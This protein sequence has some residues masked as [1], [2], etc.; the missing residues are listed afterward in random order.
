[1]LMA[2]AA[3]VL[4][5]Q[6]KAPVPDAARL[7]SAEAQVRDVFKPELA[8]A[9]RK[10]LAQDFLRVAGDT[11]D[12][13]AARYVL[14]R[15][16]ASYAAQAGDYNA[17]VQAIDEVS[18]RFQVDGVALKL[19][20]LTDAA[21]SAAT[22]ESSRFVAENAL[23]LMQY[24]EW[25]ENYAVADAAI[26]AAQAAGKK[27]RDIALY[28]RIEGK[29]KELAASKAAADALRK[30]R[31]TL[32]KT[33]DDPAA[34]LAIGRHECLSKGNWA[35]GLPCLA[36]GSDAAL[37]DLAAKDLANPADAEG[38][39]AIADA[40]W[41]LGDKEGGE[42]KV[43]ARKRAADWYAKGLAG[44]SGLSK[45]KAEKRIGESRGEDRSPGLVALFSFEEGS[46]TTS[47]DVSGNGHVATLVGTA[48]WST[49]ILGGALKLNG[50]GA[51]VEVPSAATL[52]VDTD[53]FTVACFIC[54]DVVKQCRIVN[55]WH[56]GL[57]KGWLLDVN[58]T[59]GAPP[60]RL[61]ARIS[62]GASGFNIAPE[63]NL[64]AGA[65][66][67]VALVLDRQLKEARVYADGVQLGPPVAF[68]TLG[69]LS[70]DN[71]VG[72]GEIPPEGLGW[73]SGLIDDVRLYRRVLSASELKELAARK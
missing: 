44:L 21:K 68:T 46:G 1:M 12:D 55:K 51:R 72:I 23:Y 65:W 47:A 17:G 8:K 30:L 67:H 13:P 10:A 4:A 57:M 70:C 45:S 5:L 28:T 62:D 69:S 60:V 48:S 24:A 26:A 49:G 53:S 56:M 36:K 9:D 29:A 63:L 35:A 52:N 22:P 11:N 16:A 33:P 54:P 18:R 41:D 66:A 15:E 43:R 59:N 38:Q 58:L 61:R 20:F 71:L 32:A 19:S 7:K 27:A 39:A 31:D 40:W 37:K 2:T 64:T 50:A 25:K 42:A 6:D 73:F 14:L 34:N 3:L